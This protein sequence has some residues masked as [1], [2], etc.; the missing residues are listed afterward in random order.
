M[1]NHSYGQIIGNRDAPYINNLAAHGALFTAAHAVTHPS[2]PNYLALFS[3][4]THGVT[5]DACPLWFRGPNLASSL[6]A[7]HLTFRG[8]SESM[9]NDGYTGCGG[10]TNYA[11]KHNPWVD[12]TNV[13]ASDNLRFSRF[14]AKFA[15]LPTVSFVIPNLCHD[16]HNC[17]VGTGDSWLRANLSGYVQ[18]ARTNNSVLVLTFDEAG[19][20]TPSNHITTIFAG[21]HVKPGRYALNINHYSVL[22]SIEDLYGLPRINQSATASSLNMIWR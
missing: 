11:R 10:G 2:E 14:P 21:Q 4:S 1:E 16:M 18:W 22:R 3:G 5:S 13:P 8:F 9:P 15:A 20:G 6:A 12:F 7:K 17:S 19:H